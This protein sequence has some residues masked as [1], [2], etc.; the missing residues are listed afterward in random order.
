MD[1]VRLDFLRFR[2]SVEQGC[3]RCFRRRSLWFVSSLFRGTDAEHFVHGNFEAVHLFPCLYP[4]A[5]SRPLPVRTLPTKQKNRP[6]TAQG[7]LAA[8]R[9]TPKGGEGSPC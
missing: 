9:R 4:R 5:F 6:N 7:T 8:V 3:F 1:E 2:L